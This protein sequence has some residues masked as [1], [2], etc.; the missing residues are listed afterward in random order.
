MSNAN[1]PTKNIYRFFAET[2]MW[3][4]IC[5]V[6]WFVCARVLNIPLIWLSE[7]V[8]GFLSQGTITDVKMHYSATEGFRVIN[9]Q[10]Q[11]MTSIPPPGDQPVFAATTPLI[12]G[13]GL[14]LFAALTLATNK[15]EGK[16]WREIGIA[17]LVF[18]VVQLIG[19]STQALMQLVYFSPPAI[20]SH[21]PLVSEYLNVLGVSYQIATLLL[22]PVT[23]LVLWILFNVAYIEQLVGRKI[24]SK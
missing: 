7:W 3:S 12:Y 18:L 14:A 4:I 24:S 6:A 2:L 5:F 9:Q 23:P 17:Y 19:I 10:F 13:Y 8:L 21:F 16:K 20:S 11:I 1:Q 22:P 15:D